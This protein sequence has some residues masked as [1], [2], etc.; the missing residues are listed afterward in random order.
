MEELEVIE[1]ATVQTE[2]QAP[3][4]TATHLAYF[5]KNK[6][7]VRNA[8][9]YKFVAKLEGFENVSV[10]PAGEIKPDE[11]ANSIPVDIFKDD[12]GNVTNMR[13]RIAVEGTHD[14]KGVN[15]RN[16]VGLKDTYTVGIFEA[17]RERKLDPEYTTEENK[18]VIEKGHR[19]LMAY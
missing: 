7:T 10:K 18:G 17:V 2:N 14:M 9:L 4:L 8:G 6:I 12:K 1:S 11:P 15:I 3:M 5:E 19:V 13:L 16:G